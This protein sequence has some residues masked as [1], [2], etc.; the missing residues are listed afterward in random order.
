M[1]SLKEH[2]VTLSAYGDFGMLY[3]HTYLKGVVAPDLVYK[4]FE[5]SSVKSVPK[6][7]ISLKC[8][9]KEDEVIEALI[10]H[11]RSYGFKEFEPTTIVISD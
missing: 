10:K 7:G 9:S 6:N 1:E 4:T 5:H 8:S 2:I 11:F 3:Q